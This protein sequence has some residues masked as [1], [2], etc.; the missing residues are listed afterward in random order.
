MQNKCKIIFLVLIRKYMKR[1][2]VVTRI[3][4]QALGKKFKV[5]RN[6]SPD[7]IHDDNSNGQKTKDI[8][9]VGDKRSSGNWSRGP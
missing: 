6:T 1:I 9:L 5:H 7:L 3:A 4:Q 8:K 2:C